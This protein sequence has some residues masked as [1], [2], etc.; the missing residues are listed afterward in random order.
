MIF[1]LFLLILVESWVAVSFK[2]NHVVLFSPF[3][4][5]FAFKPHTPP[6]PYDFWV[7]AKPPLKLT[8]ELQQK[9]DDKIGNEL[10]KVNGNI[11][12]SVHVMLK[13]YMYKVT[14]S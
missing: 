6:R 4:S 11:L 7:Q 3:S 5:L 2:Q 8:P 12:N 14:G 13:V 9:V 10:K 1:L